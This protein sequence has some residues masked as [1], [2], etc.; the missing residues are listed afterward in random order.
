MV[1]ITETTDYKNGQ[2][3]YYPPK[4]EDLP[5]LIKLYDFIFTKNGKWFYQ[6]SHNN[7]KI[8]TSPDY[9]FQEPIENKNENWAVINN[10][11]GYVMLTNIKQ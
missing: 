3:H 5:K 6:S 11:T 2:M 7:Y 1:T 8:F 10:M 9:N 4:K